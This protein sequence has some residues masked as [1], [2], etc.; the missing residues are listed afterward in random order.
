MC[1][2]QE[3]H[4]LI[5]FYLTHN[6]NHLCPMYPYCIGYLPISHLAVS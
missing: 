5:P 1:V 6:A 2:A 4:V 3:N